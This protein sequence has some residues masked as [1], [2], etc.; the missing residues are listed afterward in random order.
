MASSLLALFAMKENSIF[1]ILNRS[2]WKFLALRLM[3]EVGATLCY[4][5]ALFNIPIANATAILSFLPL[6]VTLAA[7]FFLAEAVGWRRY[8]AIFIGFLG[9]LIIVRPGS[10]G[11]NAYSIWALAAVAFIV[12]RDLATRQLSAHVSSISVSLLTSLVITLTGGVM[13]LFVVWNPVGIVDFWLLATAAVFI[14]FA[15]LTSVMTMRIGEIGFVSPFRYTGL[16]WAIALGALVFDDIPDAWTFLGIAIIMLMGI[17][18]LYRE[19]KIMKLDQ[20]FGL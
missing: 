11:F 12:I 13:S 17:Y 4:L 15:Y 14:V 7:S 16:L 18:T 5:P 1:P 3:S 8:L 2:D 6:A 9:I 20:S 10:E 19:K